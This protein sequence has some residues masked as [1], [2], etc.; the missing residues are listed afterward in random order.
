[1]LCGVPRAL[2]ERSAREDPVGQFL[3]WLADARTTGGAW[4]DAMTIAT[5]TP[6]GRPSARAVLLRGVDGRGFVFFTDYHS[7]KG[8]E[9]TTNARAALVF[10]WPQ[11]RRQVRIEGT[12]RRISAQESDDYFKSRPRGSRLAAVASR[13]GRA[14]GSRE[15]LERRMREV[16]KRY[17]GRPIPRPPRWGGYRVAPTAIEFWQGRANRLHDRLGYLRLTDGNW[18]RQRLQP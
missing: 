9:L 11:L 18:R 17:R 13:Q 1:M 14:I 8:R 2:N 4:T 12:V 16:S 6:G 7:R 10:I 5:A 3:E 15:L